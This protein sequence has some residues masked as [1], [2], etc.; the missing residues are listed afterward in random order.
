MA[1]KKTLHCIRT[2]VHVAKGIII[3]TYV[4]GGVHGCDVDYWTE[5]YCTGL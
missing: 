4:H 1:F 2:Y 5:L 3:R